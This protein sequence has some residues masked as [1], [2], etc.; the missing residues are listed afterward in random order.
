MSRLGGGRITAWQAC[1]LATMDTNEQDSIM[2]GS[3]DR[4]SKWSCVAKVRRHS[5]RLPGWPCALVVADVLASNV[6]CFLIL[7]LK[8]S[9]FSKQTSITAGPNMR[10]YAKLE[11]SH[12]HPPRVT[13]AQEGIYNAD[14]VELE[15]EG[16]TTA[17]TGRTHSWC[18]TTFRH[19]T[20][21]VLLP[22]RTLR[23]K[24]RSTLVPAH[25]AGSI[26]LEY[27]NVFLLLRFG[28]ST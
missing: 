20:A 16:H 18:G 14:V 17:R 8:T 9:D 13:I 3:H 25:S 22:V 21:Y 11:Y 4:G 26:S 24:S 7:S 10:V 27:T 5:R 12:L 23:T 1:A 15:K 2:R 6:C 19:T 28:K